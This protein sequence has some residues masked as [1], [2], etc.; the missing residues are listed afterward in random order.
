MHH[1]KGRLLFPLLA[2]A[3]LAAVAV[4]AVKADS[5]AGP[6]SCAIVTDSVNGAI[7]LR[8]TAQSD[9]AVSGSYR[10]RVASAAGGGN[11]NM[12]Q[13]GNFTATPGN[14]ITLGRITLGNPGAI[15]D[16]HLE[17]VANGASVE[18]SERVGG[19]I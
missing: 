8:G 15:Y 7:A 19:A 2:G 18:C 13:G 4:G 9:V 17:I 5:A 1:R 11:T 12:Q 6:L 14:P 10:F 3:A 16:A